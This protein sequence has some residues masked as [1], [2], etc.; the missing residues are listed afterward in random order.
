L[1]KPTFEEAM[2]QKFR[3]AKKVGGSFRAFEE[4]NLTFPLGR[5]LWTVL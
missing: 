5:F 3:S 4:L 1:T 2:Q